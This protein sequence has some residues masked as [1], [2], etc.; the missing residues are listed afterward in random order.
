[1]EF[2]LIAKLGERANMLYDKL[3]I[4]KSLNWKMGQDLEEEIEPLVKRHGY[5]M[6]TGLL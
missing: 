6:V 2:K 5:F 1:M 3:K 4:Q